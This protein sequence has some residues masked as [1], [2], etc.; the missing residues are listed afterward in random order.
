MRKLKLFLLLCLGF[1]LSIS[2]VACSNEQENNADSNTSSSPLN[3]TQIANDNISG[4]VS[5]SAG[6]EAGVWVIAET[7]DLGTRY[8][9]IVVTDEEGRYLIPDL[10][11]ADYQVWVRGYGLSDSAKVAASPGDE[12]DLTAIIAPDAATAARVYPAAYWYSM[13]DLPTEE[14]LAPLNGGMNFT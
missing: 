3:E 8:S 13:V 9:K 14:E 10:P 11:S 7:N 4:V 6:F 1:I 5:S 12:L 2:L